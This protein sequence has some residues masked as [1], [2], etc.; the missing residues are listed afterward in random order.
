MV[1]AWYRE[2]VPDFASLTAPLRSLTR[3]GR[4]ILWSSEC[5]RCFRLVSAPVLALLIGDSRFI[6]DLDA[7]DLCV[8]AVYLSCRAERNG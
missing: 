4:R 2:F 8:G 7:S 5:N 3:K 1:G 6:P